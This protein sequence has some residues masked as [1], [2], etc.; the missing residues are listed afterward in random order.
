VCN[1]V[2]FYCI[3]PSYQESWVEVPDDRLC[4]PQNSNT[5]KELSEN[6]SIEYRM[7]KKYPDF[8]QGVLRPFSCSIRAEYTLESSEN[9]FKRIIKES[10]K[11][12]IILFITYKEKRINRNISHM[13]EERTN[14]EKY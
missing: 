3:P 14:D 8:T 1:N 6:F 5:T 2:L 12:V 11:T 9:D 13:S 7:Q 10:F 4:N